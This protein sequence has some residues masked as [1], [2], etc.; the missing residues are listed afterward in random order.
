VEALLADDFTEFGSSG[1]V[2]EKEQIIEGLLHEQKVQRT[3][4]NFQIKILAVDVVLVT[5]H[6]F[7]T[8]DEEGP[9]LSLRRSLWKGHGDS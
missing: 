1:R 9:V 3:M 5:Y 2:Y 7:E 6:L 8:Q 4:S